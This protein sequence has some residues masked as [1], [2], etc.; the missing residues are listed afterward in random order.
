M[1]FLESAPN[2][3]AG[4]IARELGSARQSVHGLVRKL[5]AASLVDIATEATFEQPMW[6]TDLG[7][8]R[9]KTAWNVLEKTVHQ[10]FARMPDEDRRSALEA[11]ERC[12]RALAPLRPPWCWTSGG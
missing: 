4:Q 2:M 3:H 12:E 1:L 9:T 6:L 10:A 7:R 8:R 11:V 5:A